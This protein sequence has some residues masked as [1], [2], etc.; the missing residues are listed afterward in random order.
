MA[1]GW[2]ITCTAPA[3]RSSPG[4]STMGA[5]RRAEG[6]CS[7]A[8]VMSI[9]SDAAAHAPAPAPCALLVV[10]PA[11]IDK[12]GTAE[13]LLVEGRDDDRLAAFS[14]SVMAA[15]V[16]ADEVDPDGTRVARRSGRATPGRSAIRHRR[17][18]RR[19]RV[20]MDSTRLPLRLRVQAPEPPPQGAAHSHHDAAP[21]VEAGHAQ[22]HRLREVPD[23][24]EE[25]APQDDG[26][27]RQRPQ[28]LDVL[29]AAV[30]PA[31]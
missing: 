13:V 29:E 6:I 5:R 22:Q 17:W 30:A 2:A 14:V 1:A 26:E 15:F 12:L 9:R 16:D 24:V 4:G 11:R 8:Y 10:D 28:Q 21:H 23:Q 3:A 31:C 19:Q 18:K 25:R 7:A 27:R 20:F